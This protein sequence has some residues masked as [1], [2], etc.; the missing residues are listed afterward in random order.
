MLK[1]G[2]KTS[3]QKDVK[4]ILKR[5]Q[6]G[7]AFLTR[8]AYPMYQ[9]WQLERWQTENKSEGSKWKSLNPAYAE[10]KKSR[11]G[12]GPKYVT[13]KQ[14]GYGRWVQAGNW[15]RYPGGGTKMMIATGELV[16][17]VT[18]K[19][20]TYH[21]RLIKAK[22]MAIGVTLPYAEDANK[23]RDFT[24]FKNANMKLLHDMYAEYVMT[25]RLKA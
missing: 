7:R 22:Q 1:T 17:A 18:G 2:S 15:P 14:K 16:N 8:V 25:G 19:K 12:G 10:Y 4:E 3:G 11:Y 6:D 23:K 21:R 13:P 20:L 24:K 9:K 5:A